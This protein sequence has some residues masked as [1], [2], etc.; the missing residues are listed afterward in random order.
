MISNKKELELILE[1]IPRFHSPKKYLE[2]YETPSRI[3]AHILWNAYLR[4]D[5]EDKV[6]ADLGCGTARFAIGSILLGARLAL[7]IDIDLDILEYS[8]SCLKN[9]FP[10]V[11]N[12]LVFIQSD[13]HNVRLTN[14]DT[15]LMNPPFG[16]VE[17]NRGIDVV[18]LRK[19]LLFSNSVYTIHKYTSK[20]DSIIKSI[21]DSFN[22]RIVY[23]E[24]IDFPI[25]MM[26]VTHRRR[27]YRFKTV[28]YVLKGGLNE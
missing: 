2:Q 4:G 24:L 22:Y 8:V 20:I 27:V 23:R 9:I 1:K 19:G 17:K 12:Q 13:I 7:C 3:V 18:F 16:V 10:K 26:Y 21:A 15:V 14:I 25:P 5:I 6:T 28:F 11:F